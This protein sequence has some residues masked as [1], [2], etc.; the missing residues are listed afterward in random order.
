M[1]YNVPTY[2]ET[3]IQEGL[4]AETIASCYRQE[5]A[6]KA[7]RPSYMLRPKI[8]RDGNEWCALLGDDIQV[9]VCGFGNSP[10]HAYE[11][12]DRAWVEQISTEQKG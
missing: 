7:A 1:G 8:Y 5:R 6:G 3:Q 12:F 4:A 10:K 2:M 11:A 9:G